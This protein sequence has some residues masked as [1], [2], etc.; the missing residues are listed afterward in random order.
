MIGFDTIA[1]HG[2]R[3]TPS[4]GRPTGSRGITRGIAIA[5]LGALFSTTVN[6]RAAFAQGGQCTQACQTAY[7]QC[8][9]DSGSN[10]KL[11]E[12]RLQQCLSSC[13]DKR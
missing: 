4:R 2:A 12:A 13:I 5:L 8:Y 9:K 3:V 10:R 1:R 7:A 11:C 6:E